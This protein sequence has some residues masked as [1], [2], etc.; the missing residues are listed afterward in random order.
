MSEPDL[1]GINVPGWQACR[2]GQHVSFMRMEDWCL[3]GQRTVTE[4]KRHDDQPTGALYV[5]ESH[6][7]TITNDYFTSPKR[8]QLTKSDAEFEQVVGFVSSFHLC[9]GFRVENAGTGYNLADRVAVFTSVTDPGIR[10]LRRF[11]SKFK[12]ICLQGSCCYECSQLRRVEMQREKRSKSRQGAIQSKHN[13]RYMTRE[14]LSSKLKEEK[15]ERKMGK[16]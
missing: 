10:E 15:R 7:C 3:D 11:S 13:N 8:G 1:R 2:D 12:L 5:I 9:K 14:Q 4:I 6:G 16:A